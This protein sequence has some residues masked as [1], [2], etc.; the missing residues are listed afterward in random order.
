VRRFDTVFRNIKVFQPVSVDF[1]NVGSIATVS[2]DITTVTSFPLGTALLSWGFLQDAS[3]IQ[4][5]QIQFVFINANTLRFTLSNP[6][7]GAIDAGALNM[8]FVT[9]ELNTDIDDTPI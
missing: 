7:A 8:F 6:T 4:D 1:P 3:V 9:G 2:G 5:L